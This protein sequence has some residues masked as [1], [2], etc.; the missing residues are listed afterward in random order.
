MQ[1][2]EGFA[3]FPLTFDGEGTL[4]S[5]Q[6]LEAFLGA[7]EN[8]PA[9][10]VIF[11]AH[12]FRNDEADAAHL[13]SSFLNTFR[14]NL[15][16]P[17]FQA[18][19]AR[20]FIVAGVYWPSKP[21]RETYDPKADAA[22][23]LQP[24]DVVIAE[25]EAQIQELKEGASP[26]QRAKLDKAA[27]LL[28][29]LGTDAKQQ[30]RFVSLVLSLL[31]R[32]PA[33]PT[34]GLPQVRRQ[35]GSEI[36]ARL[37]PAP[38]ADTRGLGGLF[39]SIA[40]GVGTFLNLTKWY[41]MKD[42][43]GTVGAKGVAPAVR[44]LRERCPE[45]KV[46]LVGHS[47]GGRVM[48]SCAKA[49][50]EEPTLRADSL[51]LLNAAFSHYG[52]SADNG[53]GKAGFFRS[54]IDKR[55]VKGPLLSTFSAQDTTVGNAYAIMSRLALDNTREIGDASDEFGGIGRNG[56]LRTAEAVGAKLQAPG[57][58]YDYQID[59]INNLDGSGGLIRDHSDVTNAAVTYAFASAVART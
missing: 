18:L 21:F 17:E 23:A 12:G 13:Y 4:V 11:L 36:L 16:R 40:G 24:P 8:T 25:L 56:A 45:I 27:A 43:S 14:T 3:F 9:T 20:R 35:S 37:S 55:V 29:R 42:R 32:S 54:V 7:A 6:E 15:S 41:V 33:D 44:A 50:S 59:R 48:A 46:H 34:E 5:R 1:N 53:R 39:G 30:D 38:A 51:L 10:D 19:A 47:L 31:D 2:I 26:A 49:L 22:R 58:P 28:P 57:A 52:F